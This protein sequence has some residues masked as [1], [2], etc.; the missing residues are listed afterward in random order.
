MINAQ[1]SN[2]KPTVEFANN[3]FIAK[4]DKFLEQDVW[5]LEFRKQ[6]YCDTRN[7]YFLLLLKFEQQQ[8]QKK[9]KLF[10]ICVKWK[11]HKTLSFHHIR[12]RKWKNTFVSHG[13]NFLNKYFLLSKNIMSNFIK[14]T[15][16][17]FDWW[18]RQNINLTLY[19]TGVF[20]QT[21]LVSFSIWLWRVSLCAFPESGI[22]QAKFQKDW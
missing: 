3:E 16:K 18:N 11:F 22:Y 5:S 2:L 14:Y 12:Y 17:S 15:I 6:K 7:T 19:W 1:L 9:A 4:L 8:K 21:I 20:P 10:K 13:S